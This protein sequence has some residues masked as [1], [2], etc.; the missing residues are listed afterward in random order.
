[1]TRHFGNFDGP[2]WCIGTHIF[3]WWVVKVLP[4]H[5]IPDFFPLHH[6]EK[7]SL[8][9]GK[10]NNCCF[11]NFP[12]TLWETFV[13]DLL[14]AKGSKIIVLSAKAT[15]LSCW[16][17]FTS[18]TKKGAKIWICWFC[19]YIIAESYQ[20]AIPPK[21][22]FPTTKKSKKKVVVGNWLRRL[23]DWARCVIA[24]VAWLRSFVVTQLRSF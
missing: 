11:L 12:S 2:M 5:T 15:H 7:A 6:Q 1:M 22:Y 16:L 8:F 20:Y 13:T 17:A 18:L 4:Y 21:L 3:D 23:R 19:S 10:W 9:N 24:H 14:H